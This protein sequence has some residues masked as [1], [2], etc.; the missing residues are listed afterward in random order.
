MDAVAITET[1][2]CANQSFLTNVSLDGY[3]LYHT[4]TDSPKGGTVLFLKRIFD[5][6]ERIDLKIQT[7]EY[8]SVWV[9]IKN[10]KVKI[11]FVAVFIVILDTIC[12]IFLIT[13]ILP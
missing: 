13:W 2:E 4:P 7:S 10:K 11:L 1:S 9:E 6:Y 5:S 12:L 3:K 8:Q